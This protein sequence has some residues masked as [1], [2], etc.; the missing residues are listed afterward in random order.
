MLSFKIK[1]LCTR[2]QEI[3]RLVYFLDSDIDSDMLQLSYPLFVSLYE[4]GIE[5]Q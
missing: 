1:T 5:I 4:L 2:I 3:Y